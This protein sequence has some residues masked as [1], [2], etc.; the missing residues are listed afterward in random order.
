MAEIDPTTVTVGLS[1]Q[2]L[3]YYIY[4]MMD[5]TSSGVD[6][7][8]ITV[9]APYS[10]VSV[11]SV[12]DDGSSVSYTDNTSGNDI[13]VILD[14]KITQ[15]SVIAVEFEVTTP[16]SPSTDAFSD[17]FVDDTG[18]LNPVSCTEG[19]G[20]ND[21]YGADADSWTV[22]TKIPTPS[23]L[24]ASAASSS[25][26]DL[27]WK[28]NS[29]DETG[30]RIERKTDAAQG[31]YSEIATV[32]ADVTTYENTG[33]SASTAYYYRV[34]VYKNGTYSDYSN[35]ASATTS[36]G[37]GGGGGGCSIATAAYGTPMAEEV[38][39]LSKFRD[40]YLLASRAG[41][42]LVKFY[43]RHSPKVADF[44]QNREPLKAIVRTGLKPF[45]WFSKFMI[46]TTNG[47][48]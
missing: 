40:E 4:A 32:D 22:T 20:D 8:G 13:S 36:S 45:I 3:T 24:S 37:G 34:R 14:T 39:T 19:N 5:V 23:E 31:T 15:T 48:N 43:Y 17:A 1:N 42:A 18:S 25:Q 46:E 7:V 11:T 27:S 21:A 10:D 6:M 12:K 2:V 30:F 41:Q 33:L 44:I 28:D 29:D 16:S 35:E 9:P 38:N 47:S 26:I